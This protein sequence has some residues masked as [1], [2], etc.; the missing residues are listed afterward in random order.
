MIIAYLTSQYARASDTF[1]RAEVIELRRRGHTVHTFS[2]RPTDH[3]QVIS[4]EV[5]A[6]QSQTDYILSHRPAGLLAAAGAHA[7]R[8]PGRF[9]A[10]FGLAM[11][12]RPAGLKSLI[13]QTAYIVE[14][15]YLGGRLK[16]LGVQHIHN[17]IA[18][19][20]A[21]V[22]MLAAAM[23]GIT[24]STVVHGPQV[25]YAPVRWALGEK[26][27]RSAFT[28]CISHF[29]RSQCMAFS[30]V[31]H[32]PKIHVVR[33]GLDDRFLTQQP[34]LISA[35]PRLVCIARLSPEKGMPVLID[36]ASL[37]KAKGHRFELTIVGDGP[38]RAELT[39]MIEQRGL[40]EQVK[41]AGW[42]DSEAVRQHLIES[43]AMV[44]G[45]FAEGL[46]VVIMESLAL[47]RP[48]IATDI[49]GVSE[50]VQTGQTGWLVPAG[51]AEEL[52]AAMIEAISAEPDRLDALGRC[53]AQQVRRRHDIRKEVDKLEV[54][55]GEA[56]GEEPV[57]A[58]AVVEGHDSAEPLA[59]V[60]D[61]T[62]AA[63]R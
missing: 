41:L 53:G 49:A 58:P 57:A 46:P 47:G 61:A 33:C 63:S 40:G 6:E 20:S 30:A 38:M 51:S 42:Q 43:R 22:A 5:R 48:A 8:S 18:E 1:I 21:T 19:N 29:G 62:A 54:L 28:T 24:Y 27:A 3:D 4:E 39:K 23:A 36:A 10:A 60:G 13:W 12:T 9:L 50:L 11:K 52:A 59:T 2:I 26:I 7:L 15:A 34:P 55:L 25:F 17:H 56:V 44:I 16:R 31:E 14:A 37:V 32:W 35:R 45:S